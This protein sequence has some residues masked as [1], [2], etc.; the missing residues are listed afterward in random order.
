MYPKEE[1]AISVSPNTL[2][3]PNR[4]VC[5]VCYRGFA[6]RQNLTLHRRAH[7]LPFTLKT[8]T[9]N[10]PSPR[11]VYLCPEPTCVHHNRSHA[12]GDFGGVRK[13]YLRKHCTTKNF[14]CDTCGKAYSVEADLRAH[15]KVCAKKKYA[16]RC[17]SC[18]ARRCDAPEHVG[19]AKYQQ[20]LNVEDSAVK[21]T[22]NDNSSSSLI[23]SVMSHPTTL[24]LGDNSVRFNS[25]E[26]NYNLIGPQI[27]SIQNQPN[28]YH[29]IASHQYQLSQIGE[30]HRMTNPYDGLNFSMS[31]PYQHESQMKSDVG[32]YTDVSID[33][34]PLHSLNLED[35]GT[36]YRTGEGSNSFPNASYMFDPS[37]SLNLTPAMHNTGQDG[38]LNPM[39]G[40]RDAGSYGCG[41]YYGY[42]YGY[43]YGHGSGQ[44]DH[45]GAMEGGNC[46]A[47]AATARAV[48]PSESHLN[49]H[50][51]WF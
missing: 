12:L 14:K 1:V 26:N 8:R 48:A 5:E 34:I 23:G 15:S 22:R 27:S 31:H 51:F 32:L 37:S 17:G 39:N 18:F 45:G 28:P 42:G 46:E 43:G 11:K 35:G 25:N 33:K 41:S 9:S 38:M 3:D 13:H 29:S 20:T 50:G 24:L 40:I 21:S 16:C 6:R 19:T 10:E 36:S 49:Q 47:S 4:Y 44:F 7:N 2:L 30:D